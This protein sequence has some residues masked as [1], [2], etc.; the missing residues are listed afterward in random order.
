MEMNIAKRIYGGKY[1]E[2]MAFEY[3]LSVLETGFRLLKEN[4]TK[5]KCS[6]EERDAMKMA[7]EYNLESM[8]VNK[9]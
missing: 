3:Y 4:A 7:L 1:Q 9:D 2:Q 8:F 6:K 5:R